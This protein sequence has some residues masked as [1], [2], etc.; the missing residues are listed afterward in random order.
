MSALRSTLQGLLW[1][2]TFQWLRRAQPEHLVPADGPGPDTETVGAGPHRAMFF[3]RIRE[4]A[5]ERF[6][7]VRKFLGRTDIQLACRLSI[8]PMAIYLVY[9]GWVMYTGQTV[10][11]SSL[12]ILVQF[13]AELI[14]TVS[15]LSDVLGVF[16]FI[17]A[18]TLLLSSAV[19]L[20][21]KIGGVKAD[22]WVPSSV[23]F[24][25]LA[26]LLAY[27]PSDAHG[28]LGASHVI[29]YGAFGVAG[30]GLVCGVMAAACWGKILSRKTL[31]LGL[32]QPLVMLAVIAPIGFGDGWLVALSAAVYW[33]AVSIVLYT[34]TILLA[35][36]FFAMVTGKGAWGV[37][38]F[39]WSI[40]KWFIAVDTR[41]SEEK[42]TE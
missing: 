34:M 6:A 20:G 21:I 10:T 35:M 40:G 5:P 39:F 14:M 30:Y 33:S 36:L 31:L 7:R 42:S 23:F 37:G 26:G 9:W 41:T 24:A 25:L 1:L 32:I 12:N 27:A 3:R 13:D 18:V 16:L 38:Q 4:K 17:A 22:P 2:I 15:R 8:I 11:V 19:R 28:L 29:S